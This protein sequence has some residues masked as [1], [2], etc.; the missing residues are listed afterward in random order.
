MDFLKLV[1]AQ[2]KQ[3][4]YSQCGNPL[5]FCVSVKDFP[6]YLQCE[7]GGVTYLSEPQLV[8]VSFYLVVIVLRAKTMKNFPSHFRCQLWTCLEIE[9]KLESK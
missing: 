8:P 1:K 6:L 5:L 7:F 3:V 4:P 9:W 2:V